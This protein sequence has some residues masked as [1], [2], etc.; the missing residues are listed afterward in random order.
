VQHKHRQT[1][2]RLDAIK[3]QVH[4]LVTQEN[5]K[6][7]HANKQAYDAYK[8]DMASWESQRKAVDIK[9]QEILQQYRKEQIV[10]RAEVAALKIIVPDA[11]QKILEEV[12]QH[13][14]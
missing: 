7:R 3:S 11:M 14:E 6:R 12:R 8:S 10:K 5:L 13:A 4:E 9:N 1:S 2:K